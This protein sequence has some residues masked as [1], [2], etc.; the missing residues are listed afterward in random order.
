[1]TA[2]V[3][4]CSCGAKYL[5]MTGQ[6]LCELTHG[7]LSEGGAVA[8]MG[9]T[10]SP[11]ALSSPSLSVHEVGGSGAMVAG[12]PEPPIVFPGR[13]EAA[14]RLVAFSLAT[15]QARRRLVV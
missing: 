10:S 5:S 9:H 11:V 4:P 3:Y 8:G 2:T 14:C 12:N 1:M 13:R 7:T 15:G 6:R